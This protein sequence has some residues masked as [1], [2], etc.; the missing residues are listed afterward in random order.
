MSF[1]VILTLASDTLCFAD[2]PIESS[3][4]YGIEDVQPLVV[5]KMCKHR[6]TPDCPMC[7]FIRM[8]D[9]WSETTHYRT[10]DYTRDDGFCDRG[11]R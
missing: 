2:S 9:G 6:K 10:V 1:R 7:E 3:I 8:E 11:E 5:C 4:E